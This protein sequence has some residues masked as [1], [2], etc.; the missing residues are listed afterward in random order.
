MRTSHRL[1]G[2]PSRKSVEQFREARVV[3][4]TLGAF[5]IW[6]DPFGMLDPQVVVN[7]LP[8]FGVGVDFVRHGHWLGERFEGSAGWFVCLA[9]PVSAL[10]SETNE[11]HKRLLIWG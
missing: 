7:L 9:L 2:S 10:S 8:K 5:A 4:I 3:R 11:F 6:L 1:L